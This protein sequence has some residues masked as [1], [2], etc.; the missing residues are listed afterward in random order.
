MDRGEIKEVVKAK[1][2]KETL[3]RLIKYLKPNY[4]MLLFMMLIAA[5]GAWFAI[6]VPDILKKLQI[7]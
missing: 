6:W 2:F 1:N 4:P 7:H 5:I 3:I